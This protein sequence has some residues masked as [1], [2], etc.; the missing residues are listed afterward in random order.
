VERKP[1]T[2]I[3]RVF[4][5]TNPHRVV[6]DVDGERATAES[7]VIEKVEHVSRVRSGGHDA[8][9]RLVLDVAV[10]PRSIR[11]K[12]DRVDLVFR[13]GNTARRNPQRPGDT[14]NR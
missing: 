13:S 12:G 11:W 1:D 4:T 10:A 9:T 8:R 3:E 7:I 2:E 6:I 5:L 14:S